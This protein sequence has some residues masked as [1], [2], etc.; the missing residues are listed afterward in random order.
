MSDQ[1]KKEAAEKA[2]RA[3]RQI[4]HAAS[5][6]TDAA[7]QLADHAKGEAQEAITEGVEKTK[8]VSGRLTDL[9]KKLVTSET[10]RGLLYIG[11]GLL[12]IGV[13]AKK[14]QYARDVARL[15]QAD[16]A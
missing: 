7:E 3:G 15:V 14:L 1:N 8:E 5:N 11:F 12:S 10:S 13:G 16:D 2:S 9:G 4:R 6:A